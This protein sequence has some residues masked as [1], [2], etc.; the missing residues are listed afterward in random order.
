MIVELFG[1]GAFLWW[2]VVIELISFAALPYIAWMCPKAPDRGYGLSKLVGPFLV[3]ASLWLLTL[4]GVNPGGRSLPIFLLFLALI[5]GYLGYSKELVPREA[6]KQ[7]IKEYAPSVEG[8]FLGITCIYAIIR[9][10]NPEIFWG[11]KP[12]DSTFLNFFMRTNS[13]PPQDPWAS[14]SPMSYYYLGLY[15]ISALLKIS[16]IP[17][18]YGFNFGMAT[19]SG[20][21]GCALFSLVVLLTK[22][23]RYAFWS[24]WLLLFA[25]NPEVIR[26]AVINLWTGTRFNFDTVFWL[27]TR[28]F[29]PPSF[30]EYTSW[31]LLFAD[32]HAHVLAIPF[33]VTAITLAAMIHLDPATR[34]GIRGFCSRFLLGI[35]V[36][37]LFGLNTWDFI[38]FGGV[39]GVLL[40]V[41]RVPVFWEPP[42]DSNGKPY[43]GEVILSVGFSRLSALIWDFTVFGAAVGLTVWLYTKGVAFNPKGGWGWVGTQEFNSTM[44]VIRVLGYWLAGSLVIAS[45]LLWGFFQAGFRLSVPQKLLAGGAGLLAL[46]P[47][48]LSAL[49]GHQYLPWGIFVICAFISGCA[50]AILCMARNDRYELKVLAIF[51]GGFSI[52]ICVLEVFFLLDRMN[53]LFKGYMAVWILSGL[54]SVIGAYYAYKIL[55]QYSSKLVIRL[56]RIVAG[57]VIVAL[58]TGTALNVYAVVERKRIP[59]RHYTFDGTAYLHDMNPD[60]AALIDWINTYVDGT[61]VVLE[62][63]GASY[64]EYTRIA[65]HTGV[66]T[67][68]GWEHHA[69]QRGLS[70]QEAL[71]RRKA[72]QTIYVSDSLEET[73]TALLEYRVDFVVVGKVERNA[74]RRLTTEKFENN[75]ELFTRIASFGDSTLYVTYFSK[76]NPNYQSK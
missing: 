73:Q 64:R 21:I 74:Y 75:P 66:P 16:N 23:R 69:K 62:A 53:T 9:F 22:N 76:Y 51:M 55:Q 10:F 48:L 57:V 32:L 42:R 31:S 50:G 63:H 38:S 27:S 6:L 41:G 37:A 11:E 52:L 72:I 70:P 35:V 4:S 26:L 60:D 47:G 61:P 3:A 45:C 17:A 40:L 33:T 20:W 44:K 54:T 67:V 1:I 13:L 43:L 28:V 58:L 46:V 2:L 19:L 59:V 39:V 65:M 15:F 7:H 18:A 68:L 25:S 49:S 14:G 36:G 8:V 12:M 56:S 29:T 5:V 30:L 71:E 24:A 34:Y